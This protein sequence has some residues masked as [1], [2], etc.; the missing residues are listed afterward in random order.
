MLNFSHLETHII[1]VDDEQNELDAYGFLLES[2][3]V[4]HIVKRSYCITRPGNRHG[5]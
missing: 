1:L 5:I 2:M 4:K 3:G